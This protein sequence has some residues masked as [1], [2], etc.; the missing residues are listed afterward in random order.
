[1]LLTMAIAVA[2]VYAAL[3][4]FMYVAQDS[5]VY[6]PGI[7]REISTTP[8]AHGLAY[9]DLTIATEDGEKLNAWWI[10]AEARRGAVLLLHGN[11]GNISHRIDYARM[12]RK[13]GYGTLLVDYRGYGKS[14][15][16][17]SEEGTYRDAVAAWRWLT[18]RGVREDEIVLF[19][20]S[21]GA[22][23][24]AWLA[25]R[26]APRALVIASAF[27]SVP[28]LGA[29][30]YRFIPVRLLSRIHYDTLAQLPRVRAPVLIAHSA[31]DDIIPYAHGRR[32]FAAA[33]EPKT[34][35]E[36]RG[37][38]NDGFIFVRAEWV[39]ALQ[40]F[41]ERAFAVPR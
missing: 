28:D 2:A 21:L 24:A 9:E 34:F 4:A 13:M 41:L 40:S 8:A 29:E 1:M 26:H 3:L 32:L 16:S 20:E 7:A 12:F 39:A 15:G 19:G 17:P 10:P 37:G 11:A 18:S 36:L 27:T 22:A 31:E 5:L 25:A 6:Y 33:N 38:H 35:L 14:S 30:L 23:V